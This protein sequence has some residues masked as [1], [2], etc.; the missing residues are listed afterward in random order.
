MGSK[1]IRKTIAK[2]DL[3]HQAVKKMGL[4]D[5]FGDIL[6]GSDKALSPTEMAQ[7]Q[8]TDLAKQQA[9]QAD[10]QMQQQMDLANQASAQSALQVQQN[11]DREVAMQQAAEAGKVQQERPTIELADVAPIT[12]T[13]KKFRGQIGGTG[14]GPSVRV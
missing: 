11:Q 3:G 12:S 10:R 1:K 6:Y 4:P 9:Q 14:K 2:F 7:K 5:P 13:R 8:A